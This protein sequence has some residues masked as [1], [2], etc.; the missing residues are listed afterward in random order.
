MLI[1]K[2]NDSK[3]G[4]AYCRRVEKVDYNKLFKAFLHM[5]IRV[6]RFDNGLM[7]VDI[8]V[9]ELCGTVG[10]SNIVERFNSGMRGLFLRTSQYDARIKKYAMSIER[11]Q[12][13][14][15]VVEAMLTCRFNAYRELG[16]AIVYVFANPPYEK[17]VTMYTKSALEK[18]KGLCK[19]AKLTE[20]DLVAPGD[21]GYK[22]YDGGM[23]FRVTRRNEDDTLENSYICVFT[24]RLEAEKARLHFEKFGCNDS[25]VAI[26]FDE[27]ATQINSCACALIDMSSFSFEIKKREFEEIK[28]WRAVKGNIV[29]NLK[30]KEENKTVDDSETPSQNDEKEV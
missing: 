28:K 21:A 7:P 6:V 18:A 19:F 15:G 26:T 30:K 22:V 4:L 27:L 23:N 5:G 13:E 11:S 25:V 14:K 12:Q 8:P 17:R 29:V 16:N 20:N 24:S 1:K 3:A 2:Y 10:A 9:Y